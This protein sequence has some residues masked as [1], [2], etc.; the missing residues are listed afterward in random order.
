MQVS[1]NI[2]KH[3]EATTCELLANWY[4]RRKDANSVAVA[5]SCISHSFIISVMAI[6]RCTSPSKVTAVH[7][8]HNNN[9]SQSTHIS[10]NNKTNSEHVIYAHDRER[11]NVSKQDR[12]QITHELTE[13]K[14]HAVD[15]IHQVRITLAPYSL[16]H[17]TTKTPDIFALGITIHG[18]MRRHNTYT[19]HTELYPMRTIEGKTQLHKKRTCITRR[20]EQRMPF[21]RR[22]YR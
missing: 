20:G 18:M 1:G 6:S 5:P 13:Y 14:T 17:L 15:G 11:R 21:G 10:K 7:R 2:E 4:C 16:R 12:H 19:S 22:Q 9:A 3:G 8:S